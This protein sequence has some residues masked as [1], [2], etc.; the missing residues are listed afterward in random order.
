MQTYC[1][2]LIE[3]G[4]GGQPKFLE[5]GVLGQRVKIYVFLLVLAK[6]FFVVIAPF[7]FC[8]DCIKVVLSLPG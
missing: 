1:S 2:V 4:G 7:V 6:F 8:P 3:V 5:V